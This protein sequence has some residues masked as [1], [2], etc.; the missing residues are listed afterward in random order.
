MKP[1]TIAALLVLATAPAQAQTTPPADA[2]AVTKANTATAPNAS[3]LLFEQPQMKNV[4]P[5]TRLTYDYVRRS[6]ISKG[7]FGPPMD[8]TIKLGIEPGATPDSRNINVQMFSG[9]N[10]FPAGPFEDMPGNPVMTLFLEHHL[11]DLA[12]V[13]SANPR[14]IKNAIRKSLRENA[15]VTATQVDYKGA[16]V[17]GWRIE[18]QP[19]VDDKMKERMRGLENL[20]YIFVTSDAVPGEL[21]SIEAQ[22]KNAEG[23]ELLQENLTYDP[24]AG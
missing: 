7:P 11:I 24:N 13:L 10:R 19:F 12:R 22:S 5:G 21:V 18:T 3:D 1:V 23:G 17:S 2:P 6:G 4:A 15:T 14:Y 20:K 9:G 8:D 16:K